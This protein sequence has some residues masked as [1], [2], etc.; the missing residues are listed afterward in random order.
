M[1][2]TRIT[3][4]NGNLQRRSQPSASART[5][6][7]Y[8]SKGAAEKK[9]TANASLSI[10]SFGGV[11]TSTMFRGIIPDNASDDAAL[12]TM[13]RDIW[14]YDNVGGSAVDLQCGLAFSDWTLIGIDP[15]L[16]SIYSDSLAQL[17]MR[18]M[19]PQISRNY[20]VDGAFIGTLLWDQSSKTFQ[21]ILIHDRFNATISPQPFF[22]VDPIVTVNSAT[23]LQQF[24]NTYSPYADSMLKGYPKAMLENF[25]Q[26]SN[27]L[28]PVTTLMALRKGT[29]DSTCVSYLRR[30]L[31]MYMLEKTLFR[32]TLT[33]ASK[34][35]RATTQIAIGDDNWEPTTNEMQE[36]VEKFQMSEM[37]PLGAWVA[38]RQGVTL[39]DVR[40]AGEIWK[41]TEAADSLVPYKLRALGLSEAFLSSDGTYSNCLVGNS[42]IPTDKGLRTIESLGEGRV[43]NEAKPLD[44]KV[45]SRFGKERTGHWLYNGFK[46]TYKVKTDLGNDIQATGNHPV[47]VLA[48]GDHV[49]KTVDKV[50][51]GDRLCVQ[52]QK[53]VRTTKLKLDVDPYVAREL[54]EF[55][56]KG[57]RVGMSAGSHQN[58]TAIQRPKEMTPRLAYWLALF[59]RE[60]HTSYT[61]KTS[62]ARAVCFG[63]TDKRLV[64]RFVM[65]TKKIFGLDISIH[66][67]T[68]DQINAC[69]KTGEGFTA[70]KDFYTARICSFEL[71]DYLAKIGCDI[72][73]WKNREGQTPSYSKVVPWAVLEADE[74]SQKAFLAAYAE[75]DG[76]ITDNGTSFISMSEALLVQIQAMLNAH[77][78]IARRK[79]T[80]VHLYREH[81]VDFWASAGKW[82]SSK[83]P[84]SADGQKIS[85]LWGVPAKYWQ[86]I[87]ASKAV[88]FDRHGTTYVD[89]NGKEFVFSNH[90]SKDT[91]GN[92]TVKQFSYQYYKEGAFDE[93]LILLKRIDPVAAKSLKEALKLEYRYT[94]VVALEDGGK[95]HVYDISMRNGV[96]PAFVANGLIVHNTEAALT[97]FLDNLETYRQYITY[98]VF[99]SKLFPLI[100]VMNGL[101]KDKAQI[102]KGSQLNSLM[103]NLSNQ[104]NLEVPKIQWHK[105]LTTPNA[106]SLL[107]NL[108]KLSQKGFPVALKTWAA[109]A[110]VD[111][112]AAL[113][114]LEQDKAIRATISKATGIKMP[115]PGTTADAAGGEMGEQ[116]RVLAQNLEV[117]PGSDPAFHQR[118]GLLERE[119][120]NFKLTKTGKVVPA[121]VREAN[122]DNDRIVKAVK[123]LQD[124]H[125]LAS[126]K[127][128]IIAAYGKVP[129]VGW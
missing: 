11:Q 56:S 109:A 117:Y 119:F 122:Q 102:R 53:M 67:K 80:R 97:M 124:P 89:S 73:S 58:R 54:K 77:G 66:H 115:E 116:A 32:G 68:V 105:N 34:R 129:R 72:R 41:W 92:K 12:G 90:G 70:T 5:S 25:M 48:N 52:T 82:L 13:L 17:N 98:K 91:S 36:Y 118:I 15:K 113:A 50:S 44:L 106:S 59:I 76:H 81:A 16:A 127:S 46:K 74:N 79:G 3:V 101:Y 42:L 45:M 69:N 26:G 88:K 78:Y 51:I 31:P 121:S 128:N 71:C 84:T 7:V 83:K 20:L 23:N 63:N 61:H 65:L 38:T 49:W 22:S 21:D 37:D 108:D 8:A 64:E 27:V 123:A 114:D 111:L 100:A 9:V 96:E 60:G 95:Q 62:I 104:K 33:E 39:T 4:D 40:P 112:G 10:G 6:A 24:F 94:K 19:L 18:V 110:N 57:N 35:Q 75:C 107:D 99:D 14:H 30:L 47:L 43:I 55:N 28:D 126:V 1:F 87:V 29:Q 103:F 125:R 120:E 86:D 93:F 2:K 85:K